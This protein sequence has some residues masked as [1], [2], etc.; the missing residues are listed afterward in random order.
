MTALP[1]GPSLPSPLQLARWIREP[2]AF[3][4]ECRE[5]YGRAYTM[6]LPTLP[7]MVMVSDPAVI[8]DVFTGS[9]DDLY[10]GQGNRILEPILGRGSLLLLDGARHLR[11]RRLVMP[12]FHGERMRGYAEAMRDVASAELSRVPEGQEFAVYERMQAITLDVIL[13]T[14]FG[15]EA[16]ARMDEVREAITAFVDAGTSPLGTLLTFLL[17]A[18]RAEDVLLFGRR[19]M[20]VGPLRLP[21]DRWGAHRWV[22][23]RRI[24]DAGLRADE[25]L[26]AQIAARRAD[27]SG[28]G[29][30]DVLSML[31]D[32]RDDEGAA[33]TDQDL[34]DEMMTMLLAGHET[35]ATTLAWTVHH[36]LDHPEHVARLRAELEQVAGDGPLSADDVGKLPFADAVLKEA[37][38]L[39]P[40][41]PIVARVLQRPL[42]LGALEL[43]AGVVVCPCIYLTHHDSQLFPEPDRFDPDRFLGKKV[44]LAHY[45]PFGGGA[46]R[47]VGMA[48]ATFE[49]KLVLAEFVRSFEFVRAPG[50]APAV[51]RR[52]ITLAPSDGVR[53]VARRR[54]RSQAGS[55]AIGHESG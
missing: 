55:F 5:R 18:G 19:P 47:C 31:L 39:T 7:P 6:R 29:G 43:P 9:P 22:P 36:L 13:R 52:G 12:P 14:V 16:G 15:L 8:R 46:R 35:S 30:S 25:L 42:R 27:R 21:L 23:W 4:H 24:A 10:A 2:I 50:P 38:R 44:D 40:I 54:T 20:A 3:L 26:F 41:L 17:P 53:L 45:F 32:A 33:M 37:L 11:E 49:M 28:R 34:R 1:P 51:A 48:F